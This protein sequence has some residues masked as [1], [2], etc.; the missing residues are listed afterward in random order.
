[1][2]I[3]Y[4]LENPSAALCLGF[5]AVAAVTVTVDMIRWEEEPEGLF[6]V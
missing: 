6:R 5:L 4:Q 2:I 1:M 3:F